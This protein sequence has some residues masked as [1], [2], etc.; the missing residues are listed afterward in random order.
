M[1]VPQY[2]VVKQQIENVLHHLEQF[3]PLANCHMVDYFTKNVYNFHVP[4]EIQNE[5]ASVGQCEILTSLLSNKLDHQTPHLNKFVKD[6]NQCS[7][8]NCNTVCLKSEQLVKKFEEHGCKNLPTCKLEIFMT[9]KKSHEVEILSAITATTKAIGK[10]THVV[11]IGDGRGYLSSLLALH[12]KIPVLGID[13]SEINTCSARKRV[14]KLSKIW[15]SVKISPKKSVLPKNEI[16]FSEQRLYKQITQYVHENCNLLSLVSKEFLENEPLISLSGLHTCGN[17]AS[18][19]IK[20]YTLNSCVKTICNVGCCYHLLTEK[21]EMD[22]SN[23]DEKAGDFGFPLSNLLISKKFVLGRNARMLASQSVDRILES[24]LLRNK[25]IF[26]RALFEVWLENCGLSGKQ[27]GRMKKQ[28]NSFHEYVAEASKRLDVDIYPSNEQLNK[29]FSDYESREVEMNIFYLLRC[30]LA[31]VVECV[32]LLD[33][34]LFLLEQGFE[35]SYLVQ[36]FDPVISPRCYG[37]ISLKSIT[38]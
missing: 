33:R 14:A 34:L 16:R 18:T 6:L 13:S 26:Y 19:C 2:A 35:N 28:C 29:L 1:T 31:P 4:L 24:Q 5:I 38:K 17:L 11:D 20:V 21:F 10:T 37:L 23:V 27:V 7:L 8:Y 30:M 22:N 32:I 9:E 3:L 25:Y 12:Y 36:L 15:D